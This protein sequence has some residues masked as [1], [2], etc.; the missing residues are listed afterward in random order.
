MVWGGVLCGYSR[1]KHAEDSAIYP[2][3]VIGDKEGEQL[4]LDMT[5]PFMGSRKKYACGGAQ[6]RSR[7]AYKDSLL[8]EGK[9]TLA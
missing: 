6:A 1:K 5:D 2:A 4:R 8:G 3:A 7:A 9:K